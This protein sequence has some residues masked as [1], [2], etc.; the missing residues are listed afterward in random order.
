MQGYSFAPGLLLAFDW[1]K[2][3]ANKFVEFE[4]HEEVVL[5][6]LVL[7]TYAGHGLRRFRVRANNDL[8]NPHLLTAKK[9]PIMEDNLVEKLN[10]SRCL[11]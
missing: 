11:K 8:N 3:P 6:G 1:L 10:S 2:R 9:Y 5:N 4:F 7:T